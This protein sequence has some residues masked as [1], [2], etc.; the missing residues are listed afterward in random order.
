[1]AWGGRDSGVHAEGQV[2]NFRVHSTLPLYNIQR[3][4][5]RYLPE[6][7]SVLHVETVPS[8]FHAQR[9]AK[10]K[11]YEY[12]VLNSEA[13]SALQR[14][15]SYRYPYP[16]SVVK[17]RQA[18]RLFIGHRDFRVF[19]ASGGRRKTSVRTIR[20]F[21][22]EKQGDL[23]RFTVESN[24]FLYKMVR[25]MVGTLLEIGAGRLR[26]RDVKQA[27]TTQNRKLIGPT[28]PPHGLCLKRVVY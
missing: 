5:N 7:I 8:S 28:A 25:R 20:Q 21:R 15:Q 12:R 16:V 9:S 4:L 19:E 18:A 6:D 2:V 24:G 10:W 3:A 14:F 13:R 17:M 1:M 22:I 26:V 27:I 11:T 23:I